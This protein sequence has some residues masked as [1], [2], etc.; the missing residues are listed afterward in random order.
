MLEKIGLI[1]AAV[2]VYISIVFV[3][4][5]IRKRTDI[6]DVA[7]GGAFIVAAVTSLVLGGAGALQLVVTS[8]VIIWGVRLGYYILRR[9]LASQGEDARYR[10]LKAKWKSSATVNIFVRIFLI[11]GV[12]ALVISASVIFI[13][14]ADPREVGVLAIIGSAV[15]LV[16]F[17]FEAIGDAQLK[18]HLANSKNKGTLMTSGLWKYTRHPNYFGEATQWWGIFIIALSV[19]FGWATI[20]SPLLITYLLLFVSGVPLTEKRFEGRPGWDEYKRKTSKFFPLP[21]KSK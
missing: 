8:L 4:S 17:L 12:L 5:Q 20:I 10:D 9:L 1:I 15:W 19:P 21:P 13:N 16:G 2:L 7:W 6:V 18:A 11:Q 14:L 3:V